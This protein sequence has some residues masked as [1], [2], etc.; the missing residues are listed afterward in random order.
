MPSLD[1][2]GYGN[3]VGEANESLSIVMEEFLSYTMSKKSL[4]IEM[5]KLG[6][7]IKSNK[8]SIHGPLMSD[9]INTNPVLKD[10]VNLKQYIKSYHQVAMPFFLSR[11]K[12]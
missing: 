3:T 12:V 2:T 7:K 9:L 4:F 6:W 1:L 5:Q 10:I 8:N 11:S